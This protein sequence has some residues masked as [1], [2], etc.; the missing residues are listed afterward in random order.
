[1]LDPDGLKLRPGIG[2]V[3][4]AM[5]CVFK[6]HVVPHLVVRM[7]EGPVT[8]MLL[9]DRKVS[10]PVHF[11]EEGYAGVILPAPRGSIAIVGSDQQD[12]D[13]IA[14]QVFEAVDWGG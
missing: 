5:R 12:L 6:G 8:V 9:T 14:R 13:G 4:Y 10:E 1:M 11:A 3:S 2:I 7:P